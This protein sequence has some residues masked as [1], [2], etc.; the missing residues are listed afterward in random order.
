VWKL[1]DMFF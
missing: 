1:E